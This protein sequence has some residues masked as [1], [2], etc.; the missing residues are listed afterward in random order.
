MVAKQL[1]CPVEVFI[2]LLTFRK[3]YQFWIHTRLIGK[4]PL[5]EGVLNTPSAH[6][7]HHGI[8]DPYIDRNH[9]GHPDDLGSPVRD[10][11]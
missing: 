7:V 6:R 3:F 2:L 9:G 8:N 5:I 10:V 4:L 11:Y 1:G